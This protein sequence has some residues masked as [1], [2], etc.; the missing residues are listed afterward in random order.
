MTDHRTQ[1]D[2]PAIPMMKLYQRETFAGPRLT[3]RLGE[4]VV[5]GF[6][7]GTSPEGHPI[8]NITVRSRSPAGIE[9]ER[10]KNKTRG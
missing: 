4:L 8:W 9:R 10:L 5:T 1:P 6:P 2:L 7:D 3:G